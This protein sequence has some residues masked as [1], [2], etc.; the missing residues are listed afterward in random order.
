MDSWVWA[1]REVRKGDR[2][3]RRGARHSHLLLL[4]AQQVA[5]GGLQ[6]DLLQVLLQG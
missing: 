3:D 2:K 6:E 1:R 4:L 5:G